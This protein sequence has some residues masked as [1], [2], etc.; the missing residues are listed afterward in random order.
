MKIAGISSI[1]WHPKLMRMNKNLVNI[2]GVGS[3]SWID[4][5]GNG[6]GVLGLWMGR[7]MNALLWAFFFSINLYGE[8]SLMN[9]NIQYG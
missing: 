9:L 2:L 5:K 4:E 8:T 6:T 7:W 3:C 1:I